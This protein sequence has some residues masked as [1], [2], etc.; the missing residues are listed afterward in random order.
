MGIYVFGVP[1]NNPISIQHELLKE[2]NPVK[3]CH[4]FWKPLNFNRF[5]VQYT[6]NNS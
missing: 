1:L 3:I 4:F 6:L 5:Y 2:E